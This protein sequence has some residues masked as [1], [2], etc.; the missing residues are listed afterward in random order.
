MFLTRK[1]QVL[2][3]M[4]SHHISVFF[5]NFQ[6]LEIIG[7]MYRYTEAF[8]HSLFVKSSGTKNIKF[9][10]IPIFGKKTKQENM[11]DS[12]IAR[13]K[14]RK[15]GRKSSPIRMTLA[16]VPRNS[17]LWYSSSSGPSI[18]PVEYYRFPRYL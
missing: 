5:H 4:I 17:E 3:M 1:V 8:C 13:K 10:N 16:M 15:F 11:E 2:T 6:S 7:G 14:C 18:A 12:K 9:V